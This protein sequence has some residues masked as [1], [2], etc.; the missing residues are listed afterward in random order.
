VIG[1]SNVFGIQ[2]MLP[3]GMHRTFSRIL[4]IAGAM[5]VLLVFALS[6]LLAA[7]G[8]AISVLATEL[9]VTGAM[10]TVLVRRKVPIFGQTGE[11]IGGR[12]ETTPEPGCGG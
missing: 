1:L 2:T 3:L 10:A 4:M 8:T 12:A 7:T 5:N 6:S 11:V 9:F